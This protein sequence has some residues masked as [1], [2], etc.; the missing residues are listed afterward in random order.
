MH[1]EK[2][3]KMIDF[4]VQRHKPLRELVYEDLKEQILKGEIQPGTRM[5]EEEI[6]DAI[7]VS[8]TPIREAIRQLEKEGLVSIEPRK[9]AYVSQLSQKDMIEIL[10]VRQNVEGLA[11]EYA[12]IRM[13][14]EA[15]EKLKETTIKFKEAVAEGNNSEMIKYD[16]EFHH[17]I[18]EGADNK[19]LKK[20]VEQLQELVLR[21]RYLHYDEFKRSE[22]MIEEHA[23][24]AKAILSGDPEAAN[25]AAYVHIERLQA[26]VNADDSN[27]NK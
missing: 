12:A 6:A 14:D 18:V 9:G 16:T 3:A 8:R 4:T 5:M 26:V 1:N 19:I 10:E 27:K 24:I 2:G 22:Q 11:A 7:G 21:F 23:E 20:M 25:K 17:Q 15:K 13:S